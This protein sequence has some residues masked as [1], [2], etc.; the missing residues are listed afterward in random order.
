MS[1]ARRGVDLVKAWQRLNSSGQFTMRRKT[2]RL[3]IAACG[4]YAAF[5]LPSLV[6]VLLPA[7]QAGDARANEILTALVGFAL[8]PVACVGLWYERLWGFICLLIGLILVLIAF[9]PA[10]ILYGI[11]LVVALARYLFPRD[12]AWRGGGRESLDQST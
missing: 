1:I 8:L 11:C 3:L 6:G 4:V 5:G 7:I 9:P 2:F 12:E 10:S